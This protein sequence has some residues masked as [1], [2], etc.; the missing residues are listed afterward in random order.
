MLSSPHRLPGHKIPQL[1]KSAQTTSHPYFRLLTS[2]RSNS[3]H[4]TRI[5]FIVSSKIAT[6]AVDRNK[7]KRLLRQAT[8]AC[9]SRFQPGHDLLIL[10]KPAIVNHSLADLT[11]ALIKALNNLNLLL[12]ESSNS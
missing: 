7:I 10:A 9:L 11:P 2:P 1:I 8:Q 12:H 3:T 4:P 6:Q 5:G